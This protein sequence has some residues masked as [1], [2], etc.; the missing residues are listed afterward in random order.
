[1]ILCHSGVAF[2][3]GGDTDI[4]WLVLQVHYKDVSQF[5]PP[6]RFSNSHF[7]YTYWFL[8]YQGKWF[9]DVINFTDNGKDESGVDLITTFTQ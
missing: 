1:M 8:K 7:M 3:V 4:K 2:E 9:T 6:S 5:V